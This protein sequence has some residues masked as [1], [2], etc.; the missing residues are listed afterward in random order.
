MRLTRLAPDYN[1]TTRPIVFRLCQQ[2]IVE[3]DV[4]I[5]V[6]VRGVDR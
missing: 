5:M 1:W 3:E 2:V 6:G 4:L